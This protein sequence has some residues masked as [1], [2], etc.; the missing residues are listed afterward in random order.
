MSAAAAAVLCKALAACRMSI[1]LQLVSCLLWIPTS[2]PGTRF[3][4]AF[5]LPVRCGPVADDG[6]LDWSDR[7]ITHIWP[8]MF[9]Q[10]HTVTAINLASNQ[11][12][13]LEAGAFEGPYT[14]MRLDLSHNCLVSIERGTFQGLRSLRHLVLNHNAIQRIAESAFEGLSQLEMLKLIDSEIG[15]IARGMFAGLTSLRHLVLSNNRITLIIQQGAF[16]ATNNLRKLRLIN[17]GLVSIGNG[18]FDGMPYLET[19]DLDFN[20][21]QTIE[22]GA[23]AQLVS[24]KELLLNYNDICYDEM[25]PVELSGVL[26]R[27]WYITD[28]P[29]RSC[30]R[31][32]RLAQSVTAQQT[33]AL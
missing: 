30:P 26:K 21:I 28:Q 12:S 17:N 23:F 31:T 24:L 9:A 1:V 18:M 32:A 14:L 27:Y 22:E 15:S 19:L 13:C 10:Y 4:A 8:G 3:A 25:N 16:T 2:A 6:V 20:R 29:P 33:L 5:R 11:I 7:G